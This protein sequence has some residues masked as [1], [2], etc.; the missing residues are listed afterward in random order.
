VPDFS[1]KATR[2][3]FLAPSKLFSGCPLVPTLVSSPAGETYND[4]YWLQELKKNSKMRYTGKNKEE[5][6]FV[7]AVCFT[8]CNMIIF[9]GGSIIE[10]KDTK[11]FIDGT[12]GRKSVH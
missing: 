8:V 4:T 9:H 2:T 6:L 11:S 7:M 1:F 5:V 10:V 3:A 12:L